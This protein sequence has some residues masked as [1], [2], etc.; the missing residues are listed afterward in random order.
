MRLGYLN[1]LGTPSFGPSGTF[2]T[3]SNLVA[4]V[5]P[6]FTQISTG[7]IVFGWA[8]GG[9]PSGITYTAQASTA[10]SF[11][12]PLLTRTGTALS[13]GFGGL[14]ADTSY[15]F[16]V[17]GVGGPVL[18][19]GPQAT[20]AAAPAVS[21]NSFP[22][23]GAASL[24]L[25]W[26]SGGDQ[27]D[28][29]YQAE[30]SS[31]SNFSAGASSARV[32]TASAVF[33]DLVSNKLYYARVEAIGR[34]GGVAGYVSLGS[35]TTLVQAPTLPGQPFS[36]QTT[37][38][39][40]FAFNQT[41]AAGTRYTVL[42][43][44]DPGFATINASSNMTSSSATFAGLLSN[45]FYH[46]EVAAL[47]L[48]GSP[49]VYAVAAPTATAVAAPLTEAVPVTTETATSFGFQWNPGTLAP[50]TPYLAQVS[51]S[52]AFVSGVTSSTT[53]NAFA[54]FSGLLP[55]TTY[56]GQVQAL[57]VSADP[58]GPVLSAA[59]LGATLPN[60]PP[61]AGV[62]FVMVAYTSATVAWT[63]L[64]LAP[65]SAAAEGYL[66]QFSTSPDF[67]TV[68]AFSAVAPA[69]SSATVDDLAYATTYFARVGAVGWEGLANFLPL[70]STVT[71]L[72]P[73]SSGTVSASGLAL[74]VPTSFSQV[75]SMN[76]LVPPGA[77]PAGTPVSAAANVAVLPAAVSNEASL[78]PFGA[79]VGLVLSANGLQPTAPV[80]ITMA[81]DFTQIPAG[82]SESELELW[83]YD[84]N[85]L[86]WTLVP[87]HDDPVGHV[88]TAQTPHFSTFAPFFVAAGAD[89]SAVQVF[90]QP[91]EIGDAS[92]QY[93][94]SVLTFSGLPSAATVK[95]FTMMGELVWS[96]AASGGGVLT[97]NGN[98]RFGRA[99]AS[100]TYY[101]AF[102][103]GGRTKTRRLVI[104]R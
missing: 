43:S 42:V 38:G 81:Y 32:R 74:T 67:T 36:G 76:V 101:A 89:V 46:V 25:A 71:A 56:Y 102:Q 75:R 94:A 7:S 90:P 95:V 1:P 22:G 62:P 99:A 44:T 70:G 11:S 23:V 2:Y 91:W 84:P 9:N 96:G 54:T 65:P 16:Q 10:A 98:N 87:S 5:S 100:G 55:N 21:T 47:N 8:R 35:T 52:A 83:R 104:I 48:A 77:F 39:F 28:T 51:N 12:A 53:A 69:A 4:P 6:S 31:V 60:L 15:Y 27:P 79:N 13:A 17:Q 61:A 80:T 19:A 24:T 57:S 64:P 103:S 66:V 18:A 20:L 14:S 49:S 88:L 41:D 59:A 58:N 37:N 34:A 29:L 78:T 45:Q 72:P 40:K 30:V 85:A 97:W 33:T 82:R 26:S 50:G 68:A 3:G 92:S 73:L 86:Q 63:P 93:W